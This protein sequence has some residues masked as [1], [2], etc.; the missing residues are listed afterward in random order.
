MKV[1]SSQLTG[2]HIAC[3]HAHARLPLPVIVSPG[4][5]TGMIV[6][7]MTAAPGH[8][9]LIS[10]PV[11]DDPAD[12]NGLPFP[13]TDRAA[14]H[15][16]IG[17]LECAVHSTGSPVWLADAPGHALPAVRSANMRLLPDRRRVGHHAL[18]DPVTSPATTTRSHAD[19]VVGCTDSPRARHA[20]VT[21]AQADSCR[22]YPDCGNGTVRG[23]VVSGEFGRSRYDTRADEGGISCDLPKPVPTDAAA[24]ARSGC[25]ALRAK[26]RCNA[27]E[28]GRA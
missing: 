19:I 14:K 4:I 20:I 21:A 2:R 17:D 5:G 25:D 12:P 27:Q 16:P 1:R 26:K 7:Q 24:R 6:N 11:V 18:P 22:Y 23:Q 15:L 13:T 3:A 28:G 9:L 10:H 8:D